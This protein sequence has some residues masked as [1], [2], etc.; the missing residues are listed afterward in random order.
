MIKHDLF[1]EKKNKQFSVTTH[2]RTRGVLF[3]DTFNTRCQV[4][5][6]LLQ[7]PGA[8]FPKLEKERF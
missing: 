3:T 5:C 7:R 8:V 6:L 2:C 1:L 4:V